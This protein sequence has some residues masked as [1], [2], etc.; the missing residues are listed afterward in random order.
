M[1]NAN[2]TSLVYDSNV[3][4]ARVFLIRRIAEDLTILNEEMIQAFKHLN[5]TFKIMNESTNKEHFVNN[6]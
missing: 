6:I 5:E 2:A 3:E 1:Y 4:K